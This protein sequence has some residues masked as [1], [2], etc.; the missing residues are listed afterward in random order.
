[1]NTVDIMEMFR[2]M[3]NSNN[4]TNI[5]FDEY[6][7][8]SA[9]IN[10]EKSLQNNKV[11]DNCNNNINADDLDLLY[12]C[13]PT[14]NP[15]S[16]VT[17]VLNAKSS[18]TIPSLD[19]NCAGNDNIAC[20]NNSSNISTSSTEYEDNDYY[21]DGDEQFYENQ[22]NKINNFNTDNNNDSGN[23][24]NSGGLFGLNYLNGCYNNIARNNSVITNNSNTSTYL[25]SL[26]SSPIPGSNNNNNNNNNNSNGDTFFVSD[27]NNSSNTIDD[28][29]ESPITVSSSTSISNMNNNSSTDIFLLSEFLNN[30]LVN[31]K[32]AT[33]TKV[34]TAVT[35]NNDDCGSDSND[36][37]NNVNVGAGLLNNININTPPSI[38]IGGNVVGDIAKP[39]LLSSSASTSIN[40][41]LSPV[42]V[43]NINKNNN[44][45][46]V[47]GNSNN[48][49]QQT[50]N[51]IIPA[52]TTTKRRTA[53]NKMN[54]IT[55]KSST[56]INS[57]K[58]LRSKHLT[59][60]T[61]PKVIAIVNDADKSKN[62][63]N[64]VSDAVINSTAPKVI[65]HPKKTRG[66][67]PV[68]DPDKHYACDYCERKFKRQEHLKRHVRSLHMG[69]KPYECST[70][71]KRFSRSDNLTQHTKT[72]KN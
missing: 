60:P 55:T 59:P 62:N 44:A 18:D 9:I 23:G 47:N 50:G 31:T 51:K 12:Y 46:G 41:P 65:L 39:I 61:S 58:S 43:S 24:N 13:K 6:K 70:C 29:L 3:E 20:C 49:F 53:K 42:S 5:N 15:K 72:H 19:I 21:E 69:E 48:A 38:N 22:Y 4:I 32:N 17:T 57:G 34:V 71:H 8:S 2:S 64:N 26:E 27:N 30:A 10:Y 40:F 36:S 33:T 14:I 28:Y 54:H 56:H 35:N 68:E 45:N 37:I 1:M 16:L 52:T 25:N 66:R 63:N 7:G 67:K 11:T